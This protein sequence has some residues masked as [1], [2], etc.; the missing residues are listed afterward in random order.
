MYDDTKF[1]QFMRFQGKYDEKSIY[2]ACFWIDQFSHCFPDWKKD[3]EG[4]VKEFV[5]TLSK[6]KPDWIVEKAQ[7]AVIVF[8]LYVDLENSKLSD[9]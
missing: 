3:R 8:F 5:E 9:R 6:N 4:S 1:K 2:W 7:K